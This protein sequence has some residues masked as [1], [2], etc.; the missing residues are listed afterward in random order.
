MNTS[1]MV[2]TQERFNELWGP[3]TR[4]PGEVFYLLPGDTCEQERLHFEHY[5]LKVALKRLFFAPLVQPRSILDVGCGTNGWAYDLCR[6]FPHARVVGFDIKTPLLLRPPPNYCFVPGSLL[7]PLPFAD[8]SFDYV[9]QRLMWSSIPARYWRSVLAELVRVTVPGGYLE[10]GEIAAWLANM[11]PGTAQLSN[12]IIETEQRCGIDQSLML[13]LPGVLDRVGAKTFFQ[14]V[15][16]L[17]IGKAYGHRGRLME[18]SANAF[19]ASFAP[20]AQ[21][22]LALSRDEYRS[23]W[24]LMRG[25]WH[26]RCTQ[27]PFVLTLAQK[28]PRKLSS[29]LLTPV[30]ADSLQTASRVLPY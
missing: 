14:E 2:R 13:G 29:P 24:N 22:H 3:R 1:S 26:Q 5:A 16:W 15:L 6:L 23:A 30:A 9:H 4:L 28:P 17:P 27:L 11:G 19:F 21:E 12:W 10:L 25:E 20:T 7:Q 8:D 18:H